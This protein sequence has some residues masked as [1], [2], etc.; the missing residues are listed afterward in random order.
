MFCE[1]CGSQ[2]PDGAAFCRK[3]GNPTAP[4][5]TEQAEDPKIMLKDDTS[6]ETSETTVNVATAD[7]AP[8]VEK[9]DMAVPKRKVKTSEIIYGIFEKLL[10]EFLTSFICLHIVGWALSQT[11]FPVNILPYYRETIISLSAIYS[12]VV[13]IA[14]FN[15]I[16][17]ESKIEVSKKPFYKHTRFWMIVVGFIIIGIISNTIDTSTPKGE[18]RD[19][20]TNK[21]PILMF[22]EEMVINAYNEVTGENY[23]DDLTTYAALKHEIVPNAQKWL[24]SAQ[25]VQVENERLQEIHNKYIQYANTRSEG[26]EELLKALEQQNEPAA[27]LAI[28]K[29]KESDALIAEYISQVNAYCEELGIKSNLLLDES[30]KSQSSVA[31]SNSETSKHD[32]TNTRTQDS[33]SDTT[34]FVDNTEYG[35][36]IILEPDGTCAYLVQYATDIYY[37]YGDYG[38]A[39]DSVTLH[40]T[41][42]DGS[43]L[44][45][46]FTYS[47]NRLVYAGA[48]AATGTYLGAVYDRSKEVPELVQSYPPYSEVETVSK[49]SYYVEGA[50]EFSPEY[51]PTII[52]E[53][54][55]TC[56]FLVNYG[57]GMSYLYGQ[58]E[59]ALNG[60]ITLT[61]KSGDGEVV[62]I[63]MDHTANGLYWASEGKLGL[64]GMGSRYYY[65]E[66]IPPSVQ[67]NS[68]YLED[69]IAGI[70]WP[71]GN[72]PIPQTSMEAEEYVRAY[73]N[74]VLPGVSAP[75]E[76][77]SM[78]DYSFYM[79][80]NPDGMDT[81]AI[82]I[83]RGT[84]GI[85]VID[86]FGG[87]FSVVDW[88]NEVGYQ[89]IPSYESI[90]N[91]ESMSS[92]YDPQT[93]TEALED[94]MDI[95]DRTEG[96]V[97]DLF[98]GYF[99]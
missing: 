12:M 34:Y 4:I 6:P 26:L 15:K 40:L 99:E 10:S 16:L 8:K 65:S 72:L 57:S 50:R 2:I 64:S 52:L 62:I 31:S 17:E 36:I 60:G 14:G 39:M 92:K 82:I 61:L 32:G 59:I 33:I 76:C 85:Y 83:D 27:Y 68:P 18:L 67:Y 19:Y 21:M 73:L 35:S 97:R 77:S 13:T 84:G 63:R 89:Y 94:M 28:A 5:T 71:A 1:K 54:D 41:L 46:P 29:L 70:G 90:N 80:L 56:A 20:I 42:D 66:E 81:Y 87:M 78:D 53:P 24:E 93:P 75:I 45:L 95:A 7:K 91:S 49:T 69:E 96:Q 98:G 11:F 79:S 44:D 48:E 47:E 43:I 88:Y 74:D 38:F 37:Y 58:Y 23:I 3:C 22:S 55:S 25:D 9:N 30:Q 51:T 86:G